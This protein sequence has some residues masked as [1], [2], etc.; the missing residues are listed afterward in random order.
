M[1]DKKLNNVL[2][3]KKGD[4][5]YRTVGRTFYVEEE[6]KDNGEFRLKRFDRDDKNRHFWWEPEDNSWI[7]YYNGKHPSL[8]PIIDDEEQLQVELRKMSYLIA[9]AIFCSD[10]KI[11]NDENKKPK[12]FVKD[13]LNNSN[14]AELLLSVFMK[15]SKLL[16]GKSK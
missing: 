12:F 3:F 10:D 9:V 2:S 1:E 11:L 16:W 6:P 8:R 5:M 15:E 7:I 13:E 14:F 4:E